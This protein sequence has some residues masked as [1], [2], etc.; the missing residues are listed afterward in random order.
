MSFLSIMFLIIAT[1]IY[2]ARADYNNPDSISG[3]DAAAGGLV[4]GALLLY[5]FLPAIIFIIIC[6][7]LCR[8][9]C[10]RTHQKVT[11]LNKMPV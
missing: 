6:V 11:I 8:C 5:I 7:C 2:M 10:G 3:T 1:W 9:C 4:L